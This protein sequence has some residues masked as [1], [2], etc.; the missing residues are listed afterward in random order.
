[1][2]NVQVDQGFR[3]AARFQVEV[4]MHKVACYAILLLAS[5]TAWAS[6]ASDAAQAFLEAKA[7]PLGGQV[8][9][10]VLPPPATL[11][12]C[13]DPQPF[14]PGADQRLPGRVTVG[15]RC[16]DGQT[17]YLQAQVA[18]RGTY[19]VASRSVPA[20][21]VLTADM[22]EARQG[23]LGRLPRQTVRDPAA[24]VGRLTTRTLAAGAVLQTSQ[25][26]SA[27]LVHAQRQVAVEAVGAGFSVSRDGQA[28]Q[29]GALG[30]TVRVR[31]A[32]HSILTGVVAGSN[33]VKISF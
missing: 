2:T 26:Q 14:L 8:Q 20:G 12:A 4:P 13:A 6:S 23:D 5:S 28:L 17:R 30:D 10:T 29:D 7:A 19:W 11:P 21:T 22:L 3:N 15:V 1:M 24:I 16:G 32:N 33:L 25:L 9:V 18:V 27:W 31:M